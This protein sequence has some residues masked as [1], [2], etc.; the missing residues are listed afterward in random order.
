MRALA[1]HSVSLRARSLFT[2]IFI[3][4]VFKAAQPALLYLV[5]AC[6]GSSL[7]VAFTRGEFAALFA[8]SEE[9]EKTDGERFPRVAL[10]ASHL[11][12]ADTAD[13]KD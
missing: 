8:Y 9:E 5:P 3:M 12:R 7:F 4:H 6:L 13:K 11:G 2:T 1:T 10:G